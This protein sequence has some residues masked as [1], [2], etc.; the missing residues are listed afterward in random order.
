MF[1]CAIKFVDNTYYIG[2][3]PK[4]CYNA[5]TDMK[6]DPTK[7]LLVAA[8]VLFHSTDKRGEFKMI[9][10]NRLVFVDRRR[11]VRAN[12]AVAQNHAV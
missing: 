2:I 5:H 6:D 7:I 4:A 8:A 11:W 9:S 10:Q 12:R 1:P 3:I